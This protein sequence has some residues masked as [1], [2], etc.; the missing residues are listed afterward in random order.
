MGN[1]TG[2]VYLVGAGPGAPDLLTVRALRIL[3]SADV[4]LY[5]RL[6]AAEILALAPETAEFIYTGKDEGHQEEIQAEI[7]RL[8]LTHSFAG[9]RVVRLKGGD[10]FLFG[11]G[12]EEMQFLRAH[13]IPVEV[14]PGV[15]SALAAPA[16]AGIPV[17]YRGVAHSVTVISG[18]C[19]GGRPTDWAP[20]GRAGTLVILMGVRYRDRI[21]ASLIAAGRSSDEPVAFLERASTPEERIVESTLGETAWGNTD[22]SAPAVFVIGEV[23][24]L[25]AG[26]TAIASEVFA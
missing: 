23:V 13:G 24:R 12:A 3:Q 17:T 11:R 25:R 1:A 14:I 5:D 7:H 20:Y 21:A 26:L 19:R 18:R 9:R 16:L 15:S 10:P 4:V 22:V 2:C 6:V 8:F